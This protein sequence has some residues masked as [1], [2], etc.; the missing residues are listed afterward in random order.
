MGKQPT[1][2]NSSQQ[3]QIAT[4]SS[5]QQ[6]TQLS[7][8]ISSYQQPTEANN[9]SQHQPTR[10]IS[11]QQRPTAAKNV[12]HIFAHR[13]KEKVTKIEIPRRGYNKRNHYFIQSCL[14][15]E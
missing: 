6:P 15:C 2:A 5:Q 1:A 13:C 14:F 11:N 3:Q 8:V 10:A 12:L 7:A 9:N 4:N